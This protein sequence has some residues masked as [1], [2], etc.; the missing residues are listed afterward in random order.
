[1]EDHSNDENTTNGD[2]RTQAVARPN[3][4]IAR[5]GFGGTEMERRGETRATDL[6]ERA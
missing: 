2:P 6:A 1:M 4:G 3:T 5:T